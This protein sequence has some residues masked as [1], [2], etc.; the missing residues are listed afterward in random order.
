MELT[1]KTKEDL[2]NLEGWVINRVTE[3]QGELQITI[4][5][6]KQVA[7][8]L[9]TSFLKVEGSQT[10]AKIVSSVMLRPINF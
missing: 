6:D 2:K 3:E 8:V 10:Q 4:E 5:K 7:K 9:I 1:I